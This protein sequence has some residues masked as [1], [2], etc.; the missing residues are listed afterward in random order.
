MKK[1]LWSLGVVVLVGLMFLGVGVL[2]AADQ[3]AP[4]DEIKI[5]NAGYKDDKKGG[6]TLT[7]KK[8]AVDHKVACTECHHEYKDKKNVWKEGDKVKK[9]SECHS[10]LE[11]QGEALKLNLAYHKNCKDCHKELI[12]KD[13]SKKAPF[14]KCNDCHEKK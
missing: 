4:P 2:T 14:K 11:K 7:H 1:G 10:P 12:E 5:E 8:H 13:P 6:V 9:C 3:P